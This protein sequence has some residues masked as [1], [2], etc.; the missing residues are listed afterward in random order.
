MTLVQADPKGLIRESYNIEGITAAQCRSIFLDW[1][2][3]LANGQDVRPALATLIAHYPP[4]HAYHPMN[5]VL[6]EAQ[7]PDAAPVMRGWRKSRVEGA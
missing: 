1:A 7:S 3:S 5:R 2:L 4:L 6:D